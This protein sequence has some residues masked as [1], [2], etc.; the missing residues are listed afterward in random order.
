M[1]HANKLSLVFANIDGQNVKQ[2]VA[3]RKGI[4]DSIYPTSGWVSLGKVNHTVILTTGAHMIL[5]LHR[6]DE[7]DD[8]TIRLTK[9][10]PRWLTADHYEEIPQNEAAALLDVLVAALPPATLTELDHLLSRHVARSKSL[11]SPPS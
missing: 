2:W 7:A 3:G 9:V 6:R 1:L 8:A 5:E 4:P 10:F 11:D